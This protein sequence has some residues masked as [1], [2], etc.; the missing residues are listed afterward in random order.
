MNIQYPPQE[1]RTANQ[2][3]IRQHDRRQHH[4]QPVV[5]ALNADQPDRPE[6][7]LAND[8]DGRE[9]QNEQIDAAGGE[10]SRRSEECGV[11]SA[12]DTGDSGHPLGF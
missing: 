10:G 7:Q 3:D 11:M 8:R 12:T 4:H 9:Q 1:R 5:I 2:H 6:D